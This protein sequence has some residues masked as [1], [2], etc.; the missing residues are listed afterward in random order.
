VS[1]VANERK[2]QMPPRTTVQIPARRRQ[3][4]G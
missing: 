2:T 4:T 3:F 1:A